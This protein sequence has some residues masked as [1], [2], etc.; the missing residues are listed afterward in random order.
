[1]DD[2]EAVFLLVFTMHL[3]TCKPLGEKRVRFSKMFKGLRCRFACF[4]IAL[5]PFS[6]LGRKVERKVVVKE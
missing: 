2:T 1:M 6:S 5:Y 3:K 4:Y